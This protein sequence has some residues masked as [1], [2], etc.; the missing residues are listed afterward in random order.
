MTIDSASHNSIAEHFGRWLG[1]GWRG[2]VRSEQ[3]ISCRFFGQEIPVTGVS[4]RTGLS[5]DG[6][7]GFAVKLLAMA[8][9]SGIA[10]SDAYRLKRGLTVFGGGGCNVEQNQRAAVSVLQLQ[11]VGSIGSLARR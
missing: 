6:G 10:L 7:V 2:Y 3:Q 5:C 4:R 9:W 1:R 8:R 11:P